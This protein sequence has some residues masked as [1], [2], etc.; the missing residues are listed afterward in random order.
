MKLSFKVF[1]GIL[2]PSLISIIL[3][4][5]LLINKY[6]D[7]VIENEIIKSYQ[8]YKDF[9]NKFNGLSYT[10]DN[11]KEELSN[12]SKL[13]DNIYFTFYRNNKVI[14]SNND[15]DITN[16]GLTS[17]KSGNYNSL[18]DKYKNNH[19]LLIA[20]RNNDND[21]F[22]FYKNINS[23]YHNINNLTQLCIIVSAGLVFFILIIAFIISKTI[24]KP[25]NIMSNEVKKV[26]NG[27]Y[28]INLK[29]SKDEIGSLAKNINIMSKEIKNRNDEL[30]SLLDSKQIFI[31]NLSHEMNTPLTSI[32]GYVE[33]MQK[34][35]LDE[36]KKYKALDYISSETQRIMEMQ[37]KLLML[38]YKENTDIDKTNINLDNIYNQLKIELSNK[39]NSKNISISF[40]NSISN[41]IGDELLVSIAISNL[42]RNAINNSP[43]NTNIEVNSYTDSNYNYITV[44]DQGC[45]KNIISWLLLSIWFWD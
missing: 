11:L 2:I 35:N 14:Y 1:L 15:I 40:N 32:Y 28:D 43:N 6:T 9:N 41:L 30:V 5:Y 16:N 26:A 38:S 8:T 44:K 33:L 21:V 31:D 27:D 34:V 4:S 17:V 29:E 12:I 22:V 10:G 45:G 24:T 13:N 42:I 19:Y 7:S 39:L 23:T 37:K 18:V 20:I 36:D 25:L 3:I